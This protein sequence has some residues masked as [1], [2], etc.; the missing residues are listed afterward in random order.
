VSFTKTYGKY[1]L[2]AML[3][4]DFCEMVAIGGKAERYPIISLEDGLAKDDWE[5]IC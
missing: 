4:L 3:G 2:V 1:H 5:G